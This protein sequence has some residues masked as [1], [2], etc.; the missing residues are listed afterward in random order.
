MVTT[1]LDCSARGTVEYQQR[2]SS[3]PKVNECNNQWWARCS[4]GFIARTPRARAMT[5]QASTLPTTTTMRTYGAEESSGLLSVRSA[6]RTT[7][8]SISSFSVAS[9]LSSDV[10]LLP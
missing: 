5:Q 3:H 6:A 1:P 2:R 8:S 10:E 9:K 7:A 4:D